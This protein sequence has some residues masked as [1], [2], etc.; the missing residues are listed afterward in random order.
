MT[1]LPVL[2][3]FSR[4]FGVPQSPDYER[5]DEGLLDEANCDADVGTVDLR[6]E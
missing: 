2:N 3:L 5:G 4:I 6:I 1:D